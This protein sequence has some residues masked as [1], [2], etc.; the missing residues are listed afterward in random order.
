MTTLFSKPKI[1]TF[2]EPKV[3]EPPP[4]TPV[5]DTG[6]VYLLA[7]K[8]KQAASRRTRSGRASTL[9]TD[10]QGQGLGG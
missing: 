10:G 4:V 9:L 7:Q 8:K 3:P 6:D 1:P 5:A 2:P